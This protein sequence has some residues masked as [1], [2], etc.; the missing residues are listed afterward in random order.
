MQVKALSKKQWYISCL[1]ILTGIVLTLLIGM[2][3]SEPANPCAASCADTFL[4]GA[5]SS[6]TN[7]MSK[8]YRIDPVTGQ[9]T[10]LGD[11]GFENVQ[12]LA[13]GPDGVLYGVATRPGQFQKVL[14]A[15]ETD[16]CLDPGIDPLLGY[17]I[18]PVNIKSFR[19]LTY[20]QGL[21]FIGGGD[22]RVYHLD[23]LTGAI[24]SLS[25]PPRVDFQRHR[26][27]GFTADGQGTYY[28][29]DMS[30][31]STIDV[32][33]AI[34]T[35]LEPFINIGPPL[36][37]T[38]VPNAMDVDP[39][40]GNLVIS[41]LTE[42]TPQSYINH[43]VTYNPTTRQNISNLTTIDG[44]TAIAHYPLELREICGCGVPITPAC[45]EDLCPNDPLKL[46]PGVCGCG[47]EDK[48]ENQNG[49]IDCTEVE[50]GDMCP[51][52]PHK[53]EPGICGCNV[54]DEDRDQDG[55]IDCLRDDNCSLKC[56]SST[57]LLDTDGDG[58]PDCVEIE[59][60]FDPC[61][62]GSHPEI[63]RV[64]EVVC[65][66]AN[67]F[68]GA[69]NFFSFSNRQPEEF[70]TV[71]AAFRE[72]L[73]G[74][75]GTASNIE[76]RIPPNG[77]VDKDVSEFGIKPNQYGMVCATSDA[78]VDGALSISNTRYQLK[79]V[80]GIAQ[81][82]QFNFV[83]RI[84][85][86]RTIQGE[87]VISVNTHKPG[88]GVDWTV[89]NWARTFNPSSESE[90]NVK[91]EFYLPEGGDIP[92]AERFF[93][94]VPLGEFDLDL[95]IEFD[96]VNP[97][98]VAGKVKITVDENRKFGLKLRRDFHKGPLSVPEWLASVEIPIRR[99]TGSRL[100]VS[101]T[102]QD[103]IFANEERK[104]SVVEV[105]NN[106]PQ[107]IQTL[108]TEIVAGQRKETVLPIA[109][110]GNFHYMLP[111]ERLS[112]S[113]SIE[114]VSARPEAYT[115][116]T[117][118]YNF[119]ADGGLAD[120]EVVQAQEPHAVLTQ[121]TNWNSF[122][123][124]RVTLVA[125]NTSNTARTL[126]YIAYD[127]LGNI[128]ANGKVAIEAGSTTRTGLEGILPANNYGQLKLVMDGDGVV[129]SVEHALPEQYK[130]TYASEPTGQ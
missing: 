72:G 45:V 25:P 9:G 71:S 56:D 11:I 42:I 46:A 128:V 102:N 7:A 85:A 28:T 77:Q 97:A 129:A 50:V 79:V 14:I 103:S 120:V 38:S 104:F 6:S 108:V 112:L 31:L 20:D 58:F 87:A 116:S 10:L 119:Y 48:D 8:L 130:V 117:L 74:T 78:K 53:T 1:A 3:A 49:M 16:V 64:N 106:L 113:P 65:T 47:V 96:H 70:L 67:N 126:E 110:N 123:N 52:D 22:N 124:Q 109:Q 101:L 89:G 5:A 95:H 99:A 114:V 66:D 92:F 39:E 18:G 27:M 86:I 93:R 125:V 21:I 80:D 81:T 88:M 34:D 12:G 54:P 62:A 35:A 57:P 44:L 91:A 105:L 127:Q 76:F 15:I 122:L 13:F 98:G 2:P 40:T 59:Q 23:E 121:R 82:D 107:A 55:V 33:T 43:L 100:V 37:N 24:T 32:A 111:S 4:Y 29:V 75:K 118:S 41:V 30:N 60:G 68:G 94:V 51:G 26:N 19:D 63:T 36:A 84:P 90:I 83:Q 61:D 69:F 115:V 17:E 73:T